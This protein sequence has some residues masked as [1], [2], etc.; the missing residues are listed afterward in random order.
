M[1][2]GLKNAEATFQR[3]V[4]KVFEDLIGSIMEVYVD[5]IL[6]KSVMRTDH[7]QHLSKAIDLLQNTRL[8]STPRSAHLGLLPGCF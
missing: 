7:I 6:V 4:Y 1:P 2:F 5:D 8:G 3:M